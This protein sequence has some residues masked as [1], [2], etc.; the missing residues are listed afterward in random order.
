[1]GNPISE[2]VKKYMM[3]D[4]DDSPLAPP[5]PV[6]GGAPAPDAPVS[7]AA[8]PQA[9]PTPSQ[10]SSG[11]G[12]S[13]LLGQ[14]IL[15]LG[16]LLLGGVLGGARGGA[17]G[18][19]TG[20]QA[21]DDYKKT[22]LAQ[23]K[24]AYDRMK[25]Q[26]EYDLQAGSEK[27][28]EQNAKSA[29]QRA[30][31]YEKSQEQWR[32]IQRQGLDEKKRE[33]DMRNKEL[34]LKGAELSGHRKEVEDD[35]TNKRFTDFDNYL[36]T[37]KGKSGE[38]GRMQN[39][40]NNAD[41]LLALR[42][43]YPDLNFPAAQQAELA[44]AGAALVGGGSHPAEGTIHMFVPK[45]AWGDVAKLRDWYSSDP[46]GVQQQG[47]AKAML[48]T[49]QRE[50]KL[51]MDKIQGEQFPRINAYSDLKKKDVERFKAI[52]QGRGLDPD[53]YE[54][55]VAN[56]GK[57]PQ[58]ASDALGQLTSEQFAALPRADKIKYLKNMGH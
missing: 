33:A 29:A 14:A 2:L 22:K 23:Q 10:P 24:T 13:D 35:K 55:F 54:K 37:Y 1:M 31:E 39:T 25:D 51:A 38:F 27:V 36:S 56:G 43:Q 5:M 8:T 32:E 30:A 28:K 7:A 58:V 41:R 50:K 11:G 57:M 45:T 34:D 3:T 19:A 12:D 4:D 26:R 18:G 44:I 20:A 48:D 53:Q 42:D 17:L 9:A 21:I 40:I 49:A 46:H 6:P 47:F 16:P 15:G 52:L